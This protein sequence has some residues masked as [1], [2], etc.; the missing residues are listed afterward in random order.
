LTKGF[1]GAEIEQLVIAA[2]YTSHALKEE[3]KT[4][5]ILN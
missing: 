2:L 1:S 3:L 4:G 5:H